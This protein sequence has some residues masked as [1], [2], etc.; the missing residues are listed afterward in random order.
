MRIVLD[1]NVVVSGIR[2]PKGA[3]REILH[4][5]SE[6]VVMPVL[7]VPLFLEYEGVLKRE[8]FLEESGVSGR[9]IDAILDFL[10]SHARLQRIDFLWRPLLPDPKDDCVLECAVNADAAALVT[11]NLRDFPGVKKY[12][13]ITVVTP[14]EFLRAGIGR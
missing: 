10:L 7:S 3:S 14:G 4:L 6:D 12:F 9:D 1:T 5:I 11:F 13:G 8:E 2:S